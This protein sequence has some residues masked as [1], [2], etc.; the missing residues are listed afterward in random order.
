MSARHNFRCQICRKLF[1]S[2]GVL[3]T[4]H[5]LIH[6]KRRRDRI[7]S[8]I[9]DEDDIANHNAG[10]E[11]EEEEEEDTPRKPNVFPNAGTALPRPLVTYPHKNPDWNP[12]SPLESKL[13]WDFCRTHVEENTGKSSLDWMIRRGRFHPGIN[14]KNADHLHKLVHAMADGLDCER[15]EGIV[16]FEGTDVEYWYRDPMKILEYLLGHLPFRDH[17]V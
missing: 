12:L 3:T 5:R 14:V 1:L 8:Y 13:Q 15:Q 11:E 4:H 9:L 6:E 17:L 10:P 2:E 16:D 7:P